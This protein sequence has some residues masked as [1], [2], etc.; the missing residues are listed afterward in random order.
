M[1]DL[2]Q[3][4][5]LY[6]HELLGRTVPFWL[7]HGID[8]EHGG[9][10]TCLTDEGSIVSTDKYV[11]SQLRAVWTFSA[12][13]NRISPQPEFRALATNLFD[14]I[15][16]HGRDAHGD[17]LFCLDA[18][19]TPKLDGAT[20]IYCDGFAIYG[21]TEYARATGSNEARDLALAVYRRVREKLGRPGSY[22]TLPW[23][24]PA[25]LKAHG[26]AMIF[27]SAF[28]ELGQLCG[29]DEI[30]AE[31]LR[32]AGEI[33]H[34]FVD[35][36]ARRLYEFVRLDGTRLAVPPGLV[37][38]P[39]HAIESM[40]FLIHLYQ[41][42]GDNQSVRRCLEILR[43]HLELGWDWEHG[44][45]FL[46]RDAV[47]S[48][49]ESKETLKLWWPHT[50]ALYALLLAHSLCG[51]PWCLEWFHRVHDYAFGHF[52]VPGHG[53]WIQNLDRT[54]KKFTGTVALPVKDP[55]HLARSL[56]LS[57][58][59]LAKSPGPTDQPPGR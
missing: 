34:H 3:I 5:S 48:P 26:V 57:V 39:G 51:E 37:I 1:T 29:D 14:F 27:A 35:P 33:L 8:H 30:T 13:Y 17:W 43:W 7:R 6:R 20:S 47:A 25:G 11:W 22:S 31:A 24:V 42:T 49:W 10:L 38:N 40:W 52:P 21:F 19:G 53:E 16:R 55:F 44:G 36:D 58:C 59:L 12:L 28:D 54:G 2:A 45:L 23:P 18:R 41:R 50:E 46:A 15:R 4:H 56:I 9:L 32:H